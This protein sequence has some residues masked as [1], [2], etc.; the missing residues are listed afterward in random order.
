MAATATAGF[1]AL[2]CL[3]IQPVAAACVSAT[4]GFTSTDFPDARQAVNGNVQSAIISARDQIQGTSLGPRPNV[5]A[6][7]FQPDDSSTTSRYEEA[8]GALGYAGSPKR[9]KPLAAAPAPQWYFGLWGTGSYEHVS[10]T[11]CGASLNTNTN[12]AVGGGDI[13]KIGIFTASDALVV[14]I[15]GSHSASH[16]GNESTNTDGKGAYIAYVYAGFS[17]DFAFNRFN[18]STYL[19]GVNEGEDGKT[20]NYAWNIQYK[21][22]LSGAWWV[23]PTVGGNLA[24]TPFSNALMINGGTTTI[25]GGARVGTELQWNGIRVQPTLTGLAFSNTR[26]VT[27]GFDTAGVVVTDKG[28]LWGKGIAK[29]NFEFSKNFSAW[30]EGSLR[31]TSGTVSTTAYTGLAG[32]RLAY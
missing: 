19:N 22:D 32:L 6:L 2:T 23:E 25:Q 28:Q 26:V 9:A 17:T 15:N 7:P 14:G 31:G 16:F 27:G 11:S 8:F 29:V 1:V 21:F 30:I 3:S 5:R 20:S 4:T 24:N 13:T 10:T 12:A 18:F